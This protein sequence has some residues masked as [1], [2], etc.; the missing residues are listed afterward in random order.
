MTVIAFTRPEKRLTES[1]AFA[2]AAGFTVMAAPSLE[3]IPCKIS[4]LVHLFRSIKKDDI[5]VFTSATSVE[6]CG[7]S[8]LFKDSMANA[9][10]VSI[11]PGTTKALEEWGI[12]ADSMPSEYSSEGIVAHLRGTVAGKRVVLIRSDHGSPILDQGLREA[13]AKVTDFAAYSLKPADP[14]C[15]DDILD[16]GS[17]GKIDVF[18]FTSPLSARSFIEAAESRSIPAAEM[19]GK[20]KV[21]AIG[22]P[23]ADALASLRIRVDVMPENATFEEMIA[24]IKNTLFR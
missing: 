5:V 18:A 3:I 12:T 11:G 13:G 21:A 23:T 22:K 9:N 10:I 17:A 7:R 14:K 15:L 16:A 4:L 19:F 2:E 8:Q 6:E 24:S 20:A 1:I